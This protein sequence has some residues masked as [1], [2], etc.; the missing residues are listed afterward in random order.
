MSEGHS[1]EEEALDERTGPG[2]G[3][4]GEADLISEYQFVASARL[5]RGT[6]C[7]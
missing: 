3:S 7:L 4:S 6:G 5:Q 1:T 2:A